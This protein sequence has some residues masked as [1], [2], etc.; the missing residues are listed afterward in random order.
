MNTVLVKLKP[1]FLLLSMSLVSIGFV[2]VT[3]EVKGIEK[4]DL[5]EGSITQPQQVA[6]EIV[7]QQ[8][9]DSSTPSEVS[10]KV[11]YVLGSTT[12][13]PNN[14]CPS[15]TINISSDSVCSRNA[16]SAVDYTG[17]VRVGTRVSK[18]AQIILSAVTVPLELFSGMNV[19]D[20]NRLITLRTPTFKAAGEQFDSTSANV[21]LPPGT[22]IDEYKPWVED[23]PFTTN[24]SLSFSQKLDTPSE[25]GKIGVDTKLTNDCEQCNNNSN[26][27]PDKS[28]KVSEFML[29][30]T[31]RTPGEKETIT[32]E[33][34]IES[35]NEEKDQFIPWE[36]QYKGC[37][38]SVIQSLVAIFQTFDDAFWNRCTASSEDDANC[39]YVED[40]V[41]IMESPFG[42]DRDC[43]NGTCTNAYMSTRNN[44]A[45]EPSTNSSGKVYYTTPCRAII[46]GADHS[47][48]CAWDM[49]HL[50]KERKLN[51]LDDLPTIESTPSAGE[52]NDFLLDKVQGTRGSAVPL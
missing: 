4:S 39:I 51:E 49:S 12:T 50:F 27:N 29:D 28:N 25:E 15:G 45:L 6:N 2:W 3:N 9:I 43:T 38:L 20:S 44:S 41:V 52:Y 10:N 33:D 48:T 7:E 36:S 31:Y 40:I 24:Y 42:S 23:K 22:Q 46:A 34:A 1:I 19:K 14:M 37:Y 11:E 13:D 26:V 30:T 18:S 16:D 8:N 47:I 5:Q 17:G 21:L 35:C 32:G